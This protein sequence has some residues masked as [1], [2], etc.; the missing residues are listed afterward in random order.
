[1]LETL[2]SLYRQLTSVKEASTGNYFDVLDGWRGLSILFVL[3]AHLL[4]LG[5]K[6]LRLNETA[7]PIGM[8]VFFTL[9]GFL[10]TNFL[11]HRP[12]IYDFIVRRFF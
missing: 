11:I 7:G 4:P 8:A 9:S 2:K 1:M 5:P 6:A 3:A 12:N 10:I